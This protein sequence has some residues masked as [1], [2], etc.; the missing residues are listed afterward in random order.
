[1]QSALSSRL[2]IL[3]QPEAKIGRSAKLSI[4]QDLIE[5]LELNAFVFLHRFAPRCGKGKHF[6][7]RSTA[8]ATGFLLWVG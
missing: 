3:P 1:L 5:I 7:R 6:Q 8:R 2:K 4:V